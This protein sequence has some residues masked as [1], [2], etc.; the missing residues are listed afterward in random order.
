M[1]WR[2]EQLVPVEGQR[3]NKPLNL[4]PP[5]P[6]TNSGQGVSLGSWQDLFVNGRMVVAWGTSGVVLCNHET[7]HVKAA[8]AA[9]RWNLML[10]GGSV[11]CL[12]E[13]QPPVG[14]IGA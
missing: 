5:I 10:F 6:I 7:T 8:L 4:K 1:V 3:E 12:E 13:V 14:F 9:A 2:F 11:I